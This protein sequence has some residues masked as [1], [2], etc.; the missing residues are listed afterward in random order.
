MV[1]ETLP[2]LVLNSYEI[3]KR[4]L[5][6][7][8][9]QTL[10]E[11]G[12]FL[13]P[14]SV[15]CYMAKQLGEVPS[16]ARLLEPAI[17]SGVL[18]CAVI[19]R[20]IS[21]NRPTELWIDAYDTDAGLCK[22]SCDILTLAAKEAKELGVIV[23]WQVNQEDFILACMPESQPTLFGNSKIPQKTFDYIISNPP[24]FKLMLTI[25]R[26]KLFQEN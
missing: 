20:L 25:Y 22:A 19:E 12:Q 13:T 23:H 2:D 14:P 1:V 15:A 24:Y 17:G 7:R 4:I 5:E 9:L 21:E 3:G 10:K 26:S 18:V 6:K 11:H 8:Q 16:G